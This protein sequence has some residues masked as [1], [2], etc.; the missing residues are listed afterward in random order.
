MTRTGSLGS[1]AA[2]LVVAGCGL[3]FGASAASAEFMTGDPALGQPEPQSRIDAKT[4]QQHVGF[5]QNLGAQLPLDATFV[6]SH[7]KR[8]T[9]ADLV[10]DKPVVLDLV[11][12]HCPVLCSLAERGLASALKPLSLV[13][14]RDFD[15]VFVSFDPTDDPASAAE[16]KDYTLDFY[17]K[18]ETANGWHFLSGDEK[19]IRKVTDAVG[20]RYVPDPETHQFAH[21]TGVV[22]VTPSGRLSRYLYGVDLEPRDLELALTESSEGKIG[23]PVTQLLLCCFR[24]NAKLGKYT[25]ATFVMLRIGGGITLAALVA[26]ILSAVLRDRRRAAAGGAA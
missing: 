13:P 17:G 20:F 16:R 8:V 15:V 4:I 12:Y 6:D 9:L 2:V 7:G 5:D 25:A 3:A 21:A 22:V 26:F 18:A 19:D 1:L 10:H 11:Y 23:N 14:G 24:Y